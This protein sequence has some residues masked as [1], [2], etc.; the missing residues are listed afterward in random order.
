MEDSGGNTYLM[1]ANDLLKALPAEDV[2]AEVGRFGA[3]SGKT[4]ENM[5]AY[6]R[7]RRCFIAV[8]GK[9]RPLISLLLVFYGISAL[10]CRQNPLP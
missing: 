3:P 1:Q 7:K 5:G 10:V 8:Y 9:T 6:L 2:S 4:P